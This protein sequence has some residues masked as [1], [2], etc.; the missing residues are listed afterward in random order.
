MNKAIVVK[1]VYP[2]LDSYLAAS[3]GDNRLYYYTT[4]DYSE[5]IHLSTNITN[6]E[7]QK[8]VNEARKDEKIIRFDVVEVAE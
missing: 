8:I 5:A 7:V 3:E 6:D 2:N 1:G 4:T